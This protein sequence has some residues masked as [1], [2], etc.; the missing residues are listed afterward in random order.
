MN[1]NSITRIVVK[2]WLFMVFYLA[3]SIAYAGLIETNSSFGN[4]TAFVDSNTGLQWLDLSVTFNQSRDEVTSQM[5]VG[6]LYQGY[7]YAT[8]DEV[9]ALLDD[10]GL[11]FSTGELKS[12]SQYLILE[13]FLRMMAVPSGIRCCD[14]ATIR[15]VYGLTETLATSPN[16]GDPTAFFWA[17]FLQST[18]HG[19]SGSPPNVYYD[20]AWVEPQATRISESSVPAPFM[21]SWLIHEVPEP[22]ALML[23]IIGLIGL[24]LN[25]NQSLCKYITGCLITTTKWGMTT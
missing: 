18:A 7:R 15:P 5:N 4:S 19:Y 23:I 21:G 16:P 22:S 11:Q 2:V 3:S 8:L 10:I 9:L 6:G 13:N 14:A 1:F 25:R 12:E 20:A 17:S 24:F